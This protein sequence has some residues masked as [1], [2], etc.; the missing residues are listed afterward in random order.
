[1]SFILALCSVFLVLVSL[2][3]V[4]IV[5]MQ[6][7]S[8][9]SGMGSALGGSVSESTFGADTGN[10]LTRWTVYAAVIFFALS[11][12]LYLGYMNQTKKQENPEQS[13][14]SITEMEG[15]AEPSI[16]LTLPAEATAAPEIEGTVNS[17]TTEKT[18][19]PDNQ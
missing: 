17:E 16:P 8:A 15:S 1:M 4:L 9:N 3:L 2:F 12:I 14:P 13:L 18:V 5:L 7:A 10:V 19:G 6:R 11:F